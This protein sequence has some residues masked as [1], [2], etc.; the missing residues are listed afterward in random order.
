MMQNQLTGNSHESKQRVPD[1]GGH[2]AKIRRKVEVGLPPT[3]GM[4][5]NLE[6]ASTLNLTN[7]TIRRA[8]AMVRGLKNGRYSLGYRY[9]K[10]E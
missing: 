5:P 9:R 8:D 3:Y 7:Y 6:R 10:D 2:G 4:V 1:E